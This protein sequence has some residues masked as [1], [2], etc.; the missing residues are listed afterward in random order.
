MKQRYLLSVNAN[1]PH[2]FCQYLDKHRH[3][4]I[5]MNTIKRNRLFNWFRGRGITVKQI[6]RLT[7]FLVLAAECTWGPRPSLRLS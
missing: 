5:S 6:D 7:K 1:K 2:S 3:R 4:I